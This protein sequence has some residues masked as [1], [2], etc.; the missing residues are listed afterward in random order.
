MKAKLYN[1]RLAVTNLEQSISFYRKVFCKLG[2]GNGRLYEDPYDKKPSFVIGND[3]FYLELIEEPQMVPSSDKTNPLGS[4]IELLVD[5]VKEVDEFH[6]YLKDQNVHVLMPPQR[7][8]DDVLDG[9][10]DI[11]YGVYFLDNNGYK[12]G[13]IY[14][15]K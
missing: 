7:L 1:I 14:T 15:P 3:N 6:E 11:W 10:N 4:R 5:S 13:V 12:F 2:F 9:E 8:Y